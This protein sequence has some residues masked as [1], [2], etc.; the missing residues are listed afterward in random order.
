MQKGSPDTAQVS[1]S[2]GS[3]LVGHRLTFSWGSGCLELEIL[4]TYTRS[5][6]LNWVVYLLQ[7]VV[8][9]GVQNWVLCKYNRDIITCILESR[10]KMFTPSDNAENKENKPPGCVQPCKRKIP[11]PR[12]KAP[13]RMMGIEIYM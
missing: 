4:M 2:Q 5:N 3:L 6:L 8:S 9:V 11:N 12:S 10:R 1:Q 13:T 7:A